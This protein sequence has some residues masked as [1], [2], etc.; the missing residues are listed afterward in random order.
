MEDSGM[1]TYRTLGAGSSTSLVAALD[2]KLG[3]CEDRDESE[4][5]GVYL[6]D[7]QISDKANASAVSSEGAEKLWKLSEELVK[8]KFDW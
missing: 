6:I 3:A 2:P 5:Y 8:E 7:C 4:N 1:V